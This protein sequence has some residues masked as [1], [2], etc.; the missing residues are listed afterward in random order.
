M[1]PGAGRKG[2]RKRARTRAP[3]SSEGS[4]QGKPEGEPWEFR[5]RL[6][7]PKLGRLEEKALRSWRLG[8]CV[9]QPQGTRHLRRPA[10]VYQKLAPGSTE[11]QAHRLPGVASRLGSGS[12]LRGHPPAAGRPVGPGGQCAR[13]HPRRLARPAVRAAGSALVAIRWLRAAPSVR[14]DS[15]RLGTDMSNY[16][17]A[18]ITSD[19]DIIRDIGSQR[20][21]A[22]AEDRPVAHAARSPSFD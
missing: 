3:G 9:G 2:D 21:I 18:G 14:A 12:A 13:G 5:R 17:R 20:A 4:P 7:A 19:A 16:S 22:S 15:A 8:R 11:A 1:E 6:D 10:S